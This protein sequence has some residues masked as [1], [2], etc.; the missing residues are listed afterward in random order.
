M[1]GLNLERAWCYNTATASSRSTC[2]EGKTLSIGSPK[3]SIGSRPWPV[4]VALCIVCASVNLT[5]AVHVDDSTYLDIVRAILDEPLHPMCGSTYSIFMMR[6]VSFTNQPHLLFYAQALVMA[7]FPN[8]ELALHALMAL[9][10]SGSV[11]AFYA[12]ARALVPNHALFLA[13]LFALGPA[14][15]PG[16]N[17]MVDVPLVGLWLV[18]FWAVFSTSDGRASGRYWIGAAAIAL[19]CLVKY[20][21]LVLLPIFVGVMVLRR[22][23]RCLWLLTI[24]VAVLTGWSVLNWF[25]YG[26]VHLL[27]REPDVLS[28]RTVLLRAVEWIA[29]LGAVVP[30]SVMF[31]SRG[32]LRR[33]AGLPLAAGLVAAVAICFGAHRDPSC[34][35][36]ITFLWAVFL[37]NGVFVLGLVH[38]GLIRGVGLARQRGDRPRIRH[39]VVL[40]FWLVGAFLF[41]VLFAQFMAVRHVLLAVPVVLLLL[42]YSFGHLLGRGAKTFALVLTASLG[43]LL[44]LSDYR[45]AG[46]Y[47]E[48]APRIVKALP[49]GVKIWFGGHWGW[50]WYAKEAGMVPYDAGRSV[51]ETGDYVVLPSVIVAWLSP[52]DRGGLEMV[53]QVTVNSGPLTWLRTMGKDPVGGY[54]GYS[55]ET[56]SPPWRLSTAP[57]ETFYVFRVVDKAPSDS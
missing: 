24:P 25:D 16:Q 17:L 7:V 39:N 50:Q 47:R 56:R 12:V 38:R 44:A 11:V 2:A 55:F 22:Q 4:L 20:T 49:S 54:Y 57:L 3:L 40:A 26:G 35:Y 46:V 15:L 1:A 37:G 27:D 34:P 32:A 28:V 13:A 23:W 43:I 14:F 36:P 48:Q 5:K 18:F 29:G 8:S 31:L 9:M 21:S 52:Q 42:A 53:D 33:V 41:V 10:A 6:P 45:L 51:F 19:A 30:F